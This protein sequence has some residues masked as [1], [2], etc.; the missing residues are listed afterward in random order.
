MGLDMYLYARRF[1]SEYYRQ[2]E[3]QKLLTV[4]AERPRSITIEMEVAYWRKANQIHAWFVKNVQNGVDDCGKYYVSPE[5]LREL[6]DL[7]I[8]VKATRDTSLLPPCSG[9][10]FGSTEIDDGYWAD[11]DD[12]IEQLGKLPLEDCDFEY[13]ASW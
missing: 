1:A 9:F 11:I 5:Q 10:F 3:Y 12:T 13:H 2:D 6:R 4:V 8:R 7:C